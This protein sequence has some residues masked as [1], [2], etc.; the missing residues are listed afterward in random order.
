MEK[1]DEYLAKMG[2]VISTNEL[3]EREIQRIDS[4]EDFRDENEL[5]FTPPLLKNDAE[6]LKIFSTLPLVK[7][8]EV[9]FK[10]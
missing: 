5:N 8:G 9:W 2:I 7:F 4:P 6:A 10:H 1:S 3:G